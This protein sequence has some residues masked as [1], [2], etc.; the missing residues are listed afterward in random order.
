MESPSWN[1][2]CSGGRGASQAATDPSAACRKTLLT[3]GALESEGERSAAEK[4]HS[5]NTALAV[6]V[7]GGRK[8]EGGRRKEG[9]KRERT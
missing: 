9:K 3:E 8:E 6:N 7:K 2:A 1:W 5:E 4:A